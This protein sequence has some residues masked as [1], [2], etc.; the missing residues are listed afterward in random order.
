M[1]QP[2]PCSRSTPYPAGHS[3]LA[4]RTAAAPCRGPAAARFLAPS[5][6]PTRLNSRPRKF[7]ERLVYK[8]SSVSVLDAACSGFS[9]VCTAVSRIVRYVVALRAAAAGRDLVFV[10]VVERRGGAL[11]RRWRW[12][13]QGEQVQP[14]VLQAEEPAV[15]PHGQ[16]SG[17]G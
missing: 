4:G 8:A 7:N 5:S 16:R 17:A 15:E 12:R 2:P 11:G 10:V 1:E 14:E 13:E 3:S 9:G 6:S